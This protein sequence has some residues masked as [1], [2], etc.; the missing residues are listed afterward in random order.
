MRETIT[1][2]TGK[3]IGVKIKRGGK[4]IVTDWTGRFKGTADEK[5]TRDWVGKRLSKQNVADLLLK[6]GK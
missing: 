3:R 2:W 6:E 4:T 1:D 5:G